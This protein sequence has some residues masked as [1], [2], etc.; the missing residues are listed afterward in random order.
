MPEKKKA[1]VLEMETKTDCKAYIDRIENLER[2]M[3]KIATLNGC[4]NHLAEFGLNR[5][6]PPKKDRG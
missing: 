1:K 4:G 5:W 6:I 2:C 3:E